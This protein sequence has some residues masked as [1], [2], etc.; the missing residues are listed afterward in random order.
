MPKMKTNR[1]TA[2]RF[3]LTASGKVRRRR[4]YL[5]HINSHMTRKRKRQLRRPGLV[6][7]TN[8]RAIKR[9]LP[10]GR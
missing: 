10:Y 3:R 5:R 9:L 4:G 6:D 8:E 2:K 1:A 7:P